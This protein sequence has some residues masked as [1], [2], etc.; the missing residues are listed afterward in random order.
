[1]NRDK[2]T[3]KARV[4]AIE[5]VLGIVVYANWIAWFIWAALIFGVWWTGIDVFSLSLELKFLILAAPVLAIALTLTNGILFN[6]IERRH[7]TKSK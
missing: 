1:M 2:E 5:R 3:D 7:E 4:R 6:A